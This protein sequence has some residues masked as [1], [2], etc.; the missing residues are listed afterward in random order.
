MGRESDRLHKNEKQFLWRW[1]MVLEKEYAK[2]GGRLG[3]MG[4]TG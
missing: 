4:K 2:T 3:E 1:R